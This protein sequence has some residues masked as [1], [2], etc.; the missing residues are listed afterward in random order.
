MHICYIH[1]YAH[2]HI[3]LSTDVTELNPNLQ[4]SFLNVCQNQFQC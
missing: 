2:I 3:E 4:I 1:D